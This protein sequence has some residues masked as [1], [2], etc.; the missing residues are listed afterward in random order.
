MQVYQKPLGYMGTNCY[1]VDAGN[2]SAIAIDPGA[3]GNELLAFLKEK[4]LKLTKIL[5]THGHFDHIG[6]VNALTAATG[7]QVFASRRDEDMLLHQ[8]R[9]FPEEMI[10]AFSPVTADIWVNEGDTIVEGDCTFQVV[11]TPGHTPGGVCYL[12]EDH[13]FSGDTL[14]AGSIGRTDFPGGDYYTLMESLGKLRAL[15]KN[16]TVC[17]GHGEMTTLQVEKNENNYLKR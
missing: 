4:G 12:C 15:E 3:E 11:D 2:G 13:L 5:L 1:V 17:P 14:F 9:Y 8:N 16:Y 6:G 7:A 10:G